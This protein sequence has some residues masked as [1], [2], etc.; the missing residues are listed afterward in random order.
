[1]ADQ[2]SGSS[3]LDTGIDPWV[4][5]AD[6]ERDLKDYRERREKV[7]VVIPTRN[8]EPS[9]ADILLY[10]R[11]YADELLVVDGHSTD[12]TREVAASQGVRVILDSGQGKGA[13][14]RQAISSSTRPI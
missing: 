11:P 12:R 14:L 10:C 5:R 1:M 13:A 4:S 9:I 3:P 7:S 2:F 8:E 6:D